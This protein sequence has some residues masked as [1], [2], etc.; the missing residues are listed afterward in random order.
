M[1]WTSPNWITQQ[2][3]DYFHHLKA[4]QDIEFVVYQF[5]GSRCDEPVL[6]NS[7]LRKKLSECK[8]YEEAVRAAVSYGDRCFIIKLE[9]GTVTEVW[10]DR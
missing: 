7:W 5:D 6:R 1:S 3:K 10:S 8:S 9:D 4:S 2:M